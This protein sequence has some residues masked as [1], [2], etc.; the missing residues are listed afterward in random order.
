MV[1]Y[2][3]EEL[4]T[5]LLG[6][7]LVFL[8]SKKYPHVHTRRIDWI[9][10]KTAIFSFQH[11][12]LPAILVIPYDNNIL[13]WNAMK[14]SN[15][16]PANPTPEAY[17]KQMLDFLGMIAYDGVST[18]PS[19]TTEETTTAMPFT[20]TSMTPLLSGPGKYT[21]GA[22]APYDCEF[23]NHGHITFFQT[24]ISIPPT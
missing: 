20:T 9:Y 19:A 1:A 17:K 8:A 22:N 12:N 5:G 7:D 11:L 15:P 14:V 6:R 13:N 18:T 24:N 21:F 2:V 16:T 10:A 23:M 3:V 4:N